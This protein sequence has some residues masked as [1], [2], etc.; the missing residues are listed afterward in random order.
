MHSTIIRAI[1]LFYNG[2]VD[3]L[4]GDIRKNTLQLHYLE[5]T[6]FLCQIGFLLAGFKPNAKSTNFFR[7]DSE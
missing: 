6:R 2:Q 7:I 5:T 1:N 3:H 4:S